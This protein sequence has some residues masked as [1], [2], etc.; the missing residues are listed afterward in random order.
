[1]VVPKVG[2][3]RGPVNIEVDLAGVIP[4]TVEVHVDHLLP[5][6]LDCIVCKTH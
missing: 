6:L 2:A 3:S 5:F 4:D 1:M